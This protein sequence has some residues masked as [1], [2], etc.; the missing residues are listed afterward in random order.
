MNPTHLSFKVF[1][2]VLYESLQSA[3]GL[4]TLTKNLMT[5]KNNNFFFGQLDE[6]MGLIELLQDFG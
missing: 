4:L 5:N 3:H 2:V 1:E 6:L